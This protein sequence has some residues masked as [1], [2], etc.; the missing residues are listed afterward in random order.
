ARRGVI[1]RQVDQ[2]DG[3][4]MKGRVAVLRRRRLERRDPVLVE[5]RRSP[6][7]GRSR[8]DLYGIRPHRL[9]ALE[10]KV[11]A[12]GRIDVSSKNRHPRERN[13]GSIWHAGRALLVFVMG[14]LYLAMRCC[15]YG[16]SDV[17]DW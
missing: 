15:T 5:L 8:V 7:P 1:A 9:G 10:R 14:E 16:D 12:S 3:V 2:V 17:L 4:K 6:E 13:S 11:E